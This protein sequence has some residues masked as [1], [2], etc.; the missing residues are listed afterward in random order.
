MALLPRARRRD[1]AAERGVGHL[2][3]C[4]RDHVRAG[5]L[6]GRGEL[7]VPPVRRPGGL[8]ARAPRDPR[9]A[10]AAQGRAGGLNSS[11]SSP[12]SAA[13]RLGAQGR[14]GDSD[15]AHDPASSPTSSTL[16]QPGACSRLRKRRPPVKAYERIARFT[17]PCRTARTTSQSGVASSRSRAGSTRSSSDPIV[18]PEKGRLLGTTSRQAFTTRSPAGL[19]GLSPRRPDSISRSLRPL[20]GSI[21]GATSR[22]VSTVRG[23]R[24]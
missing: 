7:P 19:Q 24:L 22:A 6:R 16:T 4:P 10:R 1:G 11:Q 8:R 23:D 14:R 5:F 13:G 20:L 9:A 21:A 15:G 12:S 17:A 18:S 3:Q 2:A